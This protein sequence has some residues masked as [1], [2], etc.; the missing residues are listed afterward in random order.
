MSRL[1][2]SIRKENLF[3][4]ARQDMFERGENSG[5]KEWGHFQT[6]PCTVPPA[7]GDL[8]P[9]KCTRCNTV[10]NYC[11]VPNSA[12]LLCTT[13][14]VFSHV[15]Y[16][17]PAASRCPLSNTI[18]LGATEPNQQGADHVTSLMAKMSTRCCSRLSTIWCP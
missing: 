10:S 5:W 4:G 7:R 18:L 14:A 6:E 13:H 12:I 3:R 9:E 11:K 17:Y 2:K 8:K 16:H 15:A 1:Y